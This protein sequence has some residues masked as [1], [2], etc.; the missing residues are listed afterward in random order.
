LP[1]GL[2]RG[3]T[4]FN[5]NFLCS[6]CKEIA[7]SEK[8]SAPTACLAVEISELHW[9]SSGG[10]IAWKG[11]RKGRL[12]STTPPTHSSTILL[13]GGCK[14]K[15]DQTLVDLSLSLIRTRVLSYNEHLRLSKRRLY[16]NINDLCHLVAKSVGLLRTDIALVTKIAEGGS[17]RIFEATFHNGMKVIARLSYPCTIHGSEYIIMERVSGSELADT[18]HTMTFKERMAV[19]KKTVDLERLLFG[20]RFPASGSLFFQRFLGS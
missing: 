1:A 5:F 7:S 9:Q 16:F 10:N 18:W 8:L 15:T 17:Y 2:Y 14:Y 11:L 13:V 3:G 19:V 20:I 6:Q 12:R 4:F